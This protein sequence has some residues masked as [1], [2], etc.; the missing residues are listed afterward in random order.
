[1][2][3]KFETLNI[4]TSYNKDNYFTV[5][6]DGE[7]NTLKAFVNGNLVETRKWD[8]SEGVWNHFINESLER[9]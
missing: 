2:F 9:M 3:S 4:D 5:T 1:M 7:N 8:E 6:V